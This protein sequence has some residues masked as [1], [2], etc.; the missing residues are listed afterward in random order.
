MSFIQFCLTFLPN[1]TSLEKVASKSERV[2]EREKER[3]ESYI[4]SSPQLN[5]LVA[6]NIIQA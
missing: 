6:L 4:N 3:E 5:L 2:S 1:L